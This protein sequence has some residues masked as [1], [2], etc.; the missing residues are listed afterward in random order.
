MTLRIVGHVDTDDCDLLV[1][2]TS[3]D[4]ASSEDEEEGEQRQHDE[5]IERMGV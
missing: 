2:G 4:E 5:T 3:R 1:E